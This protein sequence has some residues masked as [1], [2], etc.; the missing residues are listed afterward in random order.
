M[1]R[2]L[3]FTP[4]HKLKYIR[5]LKE[6]PDILVIDL[7][8]SVPQ[9]KKDIA[10]QTTQNFL[11]ENYYNKSKI[12]VRIPYN[13]KFIEKKYQKIINKNLTGFILPKVQNKNDLKIL[14]KFVVKQEKLKKIKKKFRLSFIAETTNSIV[15]LNDIIK[16]TD[17]IDFIIYGEED[18]HADLNG[19]N[20]SEKLNNNYAK[21]FIPIL[22]KSNNVQA[23]FTPYLYL[24]N[25]KGLKKHILDSVKLGY[26]GLLLIHPSQINLTNK[27][28]MPSN[29]DL[30]IA[31]QILASNKTKKYEGQNISVLKNK[32]IGPPMIRRAQK[33][34]DLYNKK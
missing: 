34:I 18:Y 1:Y 16:S 31:K 12:Y 32:L 21:N 7:E 30:E 8:D 11:E 29:K 24:K 15:N 19:I 6:F 33:I 3:L 10:L 28:Y 13:N 22:A 17:R 5:S 9:T 4:G 26:S 2:S 23:I 27:F 14:L 20:F 25:L